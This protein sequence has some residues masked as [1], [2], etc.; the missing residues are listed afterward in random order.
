MLLSKPTNKSSLSSYINYKRQA[1][2]IRFFLL[3][4]LIKRE[5]LEREIIFYPCLQQAFLLFNGIE[6]PIN[7]LTEFEFFP[8]NI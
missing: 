5:C 6:T 2:I 1:A 8:K 3:E 7:P 4:K